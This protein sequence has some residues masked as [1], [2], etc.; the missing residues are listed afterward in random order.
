MQRGPTSDER[1]YL[2]MMYEEN[3]EHARQHEDM[4][5]TA[6]GLFVA[7]I[8]GVMAFA[9]G[10]NEHRIVVSGIVVCAVSVLGGLIS[11]KHYERYELHLR[12][13]RDYRTALELGLDPTYPMLKNEAD[14]KHEER[15]P[16]TH[17]WLKLHVLWLF[18]YL[19]TFMIGCLMIMWSKAVTLF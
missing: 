13:A 16:T 6:T 18:V 8:A 12:R 5:G 7:L 4:R 2:R 11:Y 10:D 9:A 1:D 14:R 3:S 15:Y 17:R 19:A